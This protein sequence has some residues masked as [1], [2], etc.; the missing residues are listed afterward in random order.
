MKYINHQFNC[1]LVGIAI[2]SLSSCNTDK[3]IVTTDDSFKNKVSKC[4]ADEVDGRLIHGDASPLV[5]MDPTCGRLSYGLYANEGQPSKVNIL[6]DFSYAGYMKGGVKLP[7]VSV[8]ITLSHQFGDQYSRIQSAINTVSARTPDSK[9]FRGAILLEA[10]DWETS[11]TI[12]ISASG[13]VLRGEGP[14]TGGTVLIATKSEKHDLIRLEG[15]SSGLGEVL[16]TEVD[17][18]SSY[19]PVGAN[20]F[21]VEDASGFSV[22]DAIGVRRTP[23]KN[24]LEDTNMVQW[25]WTTGAYTIDHERTITKISGNSITVDI[26]I[27][28]TMESQYG[29]GTIF[30]SD[31]SGRIE[32]SG[33]ENIRLVSEYLGVEDE[34]HGWNA[35]VFSRATNSWVKQ[36]TAQNFGYSAVSMTKNSSFNTVEEVAQLDPI[37][38]VTGGRRY[39][40]YVRGG[41][42]NL[43]NRCYSR[44]ARHNFVTGARVT[45][46]NVWLDSL[47]EK[48]NS[49]DGPH[50][51]WAVGLLF[52]NLSSASFRTQNR[53]DSGSGHGWAGAQTMLWNIEA[54]S[55]IVNDAPEGAMN[56]S[57]GS[58][59]EIKEGYWAPEAPAG[60]FEYHG[61]HTLPRS[62]YLSQLKDRLGE[63]AV[64]AITTEEQ[65]L[66]TIWNRLRGWAGEGLLEDATPIE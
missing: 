3:N 18:T 43:F 51:R 5:K 66:G 26:P 29:G 58:I 61:S 46:P 7:N 40:F 44:D 19:V 16:G 54:S 22:G 56:W 32:Q 1:L 27:V 52:D 33:V 24:W 50:H 62:L 60:M 9:G 14:E 31:M 30:L 47:A 35:I 13:V 59:G 34:N 57:V 23:N 37:S 21:T 8:A 6:P 17:I 49:D 4:T 63:D 64:K 39:S 36:V 15:S 20:S 10:G 65:R 28:D 38:I 11:D 2:L 55:A 53:E 12:I 25:G 45:G 48:N 42:G 41:T